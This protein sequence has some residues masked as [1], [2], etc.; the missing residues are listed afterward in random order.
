MPVTDI[1]TNQDTSFYDHWYKP[2]TEWNRIPCNVVKLPD[3]YSFDLDKLRAQVDG[4]EQNHGY[5]PFPIKKDGSKVRRT[6]QGIGLT[7]KEGAEDP[8][9]DALKL[10]G[11]DAELDIT[12]VF[13]KQRNG[14]ADK[15]AA[16]LAEKDFQVPTEIYTG[17]VAEVLSKFN[18]PL[19]KTRLLNLKRRGIIAPHVDFPYYKQI[20]VHA[21]IKTNEHTWWEVEGQ[22]FQIPAD[23][24]FYWFDTGKYHA[25]WNDGVSDRIVLSVNLSVYEERDGTP[26]FGPDTSLLSLLTTA[27]V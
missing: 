20:R 23:G 1:N 12:D 7:A 18:S 8:L 3:H 4:I 9:Y 6:Y 14:I 27:Q 13:L 5:R 21:V 26:R 25:V 2:H 19:T 16:E 17:Y 10:Y 11:K 22:K 15:E 24:N